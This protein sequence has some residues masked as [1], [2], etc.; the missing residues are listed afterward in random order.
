VQILIGALSSDEGLA[1][2][3]YAKT[4]PNVAFV[5]GTSAAQDTTLRDS[6]PNF[7]RFSTDGAQWIAGLG[8]R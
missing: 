3:G 8:S 4:Q 6:A 1:V 5:N 7:F 2:K